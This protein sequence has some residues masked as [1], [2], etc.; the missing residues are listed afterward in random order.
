MQQY[1]KSAFLLS[2]LILTLAFG[3]FIFAWQ[4]P[5]Q[6]PPGGNVNKLT[7]EELNILSTS[8]FSGKLIFQSGIE[9]TTT[10]GSPISGLNADLLDNVNASE[11]VDQ[12]VA[13]AGGGSCFSEIQGWDGS[14]WVK[15]ADFG[16]MTDKIYDPDGNYYELISG[17]VYK[18]GSLLY[19][20]RSK[21]AVDDTKWTA[22]SSE[23]TGCTFSTS[24]ICD[25]WGCPCEPSCSKKKEWIPPV[26]Q[27]QTFNNPT[28]TCGYA[29]A[30]CIEGNSY[31][32]DAEFKRDTNAEKFCQEQGYETYSSYTLTTL[33]HGNC[34]VEWSHWQNKWA[35]A[36]QTWADIDVFS[37]ITC[38][39]TTPGYWQWYREGNVYFKCSDYM[40][41]Q[42]T[43]LRVK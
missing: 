17:K 9:A 32:I 4:E 41:P 29:Y 5:S 26:T 37:S 8:T 1:K 19:L 22:V 15:L 25:D 33:P 14:N 23:P 10:S 13:M 20:K 40:I 12:A 36:K 7:L 43:K 30:Y 38:T 28:R 42:F 2:A 27:T 3:Y 16:W 39:K 18:N 35:C 21:W 11:I 31:P 24:G 34:Y 6:N